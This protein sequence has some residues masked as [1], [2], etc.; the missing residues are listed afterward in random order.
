MLVNPYTQLIV[1]VTYTLLSV[2][3]TGFLILFATIE[4]EQFLS[5]AIGTLSFYSDF[6]WVSVLF[7]VAFGLIGLLSPLN[8]KVIWYNF[9]LFLSLPIALIGVFG[10]VIL[11]LCG[12]CCSFYCIRKLYEG[13][14]LV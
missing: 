8:E 2:C 14:K 3:I 4:G 9:F 5:I 6:I 12:I 10:T 11:I 1:T 13:I 7:V